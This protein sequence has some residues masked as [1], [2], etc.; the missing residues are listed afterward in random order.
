MLL[1]RQ[2]FLNFSFVNS[3]PI[4]KVGCY[5]CPNRKTSKQGSFSP[6]RAKN[7]QRVSFSGLDD[8]KIVKTK[9]KETREI[10][11]VV[12]TITIS[13]FFI[14]HIGH[15]QQK[16]LPSGNFKFV[17][18]PE[19]VAKKIIENYSPEDSTGFIL[20]VDLVSLL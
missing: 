4:K 19:Q 3:L 8:K 16:K 2:N 17:D 12:K 11:K 6:A 1:S 15:C 18:D 20:N 13:F 5:F 14:Y 9:T 7:S 10:E